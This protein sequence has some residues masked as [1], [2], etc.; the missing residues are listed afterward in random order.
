M[1]LLKLGEKFR[2]VSA[3]NMNDV[4]SRSHTYSGEISL[5]IQAVHALYL[6]D[7]RGRFF[8]TQYSQSRRFGR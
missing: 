3:T 1:S 5:K 8:Q 6:T 7:V 2:A 4:S